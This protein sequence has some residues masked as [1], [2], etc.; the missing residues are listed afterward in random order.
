MNELIAYE[1][2]RMTKLHLDQILSASFTEIDVQLIIETM[3]MSTEFENELH[4]KFS[5]STQQEGRRVFKFEGCISQCFEPYLRSYS[6]AESRKLSSEI[7]NRTRDDS[8]EAMNPDVFTSSL[9]L[10][11]EVK[12]SLNRCLSFSKSKALFDLTQTFKNTLRLYV[13]L[14]KRKLPNKG[15][16]AVLLSEEQEMTCVYLVNTCEYCLE[17]IPK[18]HTMIEDKI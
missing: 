14:L 18:L 17:T 10:F 13:Q 8:L 3:Q 5:A 11:K 1:F 4:K 16:Q 7:E 9:Y 12:A 2:C 6:E 15:D